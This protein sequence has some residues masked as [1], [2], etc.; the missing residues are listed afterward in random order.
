MSKGDVSFLLV[1]TCVI[2]VVTTASAFFT[3]G[4]YFA[5]LV[6]AAILACLLFLQHPRSALAAALIAV[7]V[8]PTLVVITGVSRVSLLDDGLTLACFIYLPLRRVLGG[9]QLRRLPG[10][11][12]FVLV[13]TAGLISGLA[14]DVP[15]SIS[16][17]GGYLL[18][19]GPMLGY[20]AAQLDWRQSDVV[21]LRKLVIRAT[22]LLLTC[23]TANLALP[24]QWAAVFASTGLAD[25]RYS[26]IASLLGPFTHPSFMG[27][28]LGLCVVA[29]LAFDGDGNRRTWPLTAL[30][31]VAAFL[32][33]RRKTLV[34]L[35]LAVLTVI[36]IRSRIA[37]MSFA[38]PLVAVAIAFGWV[39]I[40]G[41]A[42]T[43]YHAYFVDSTIVPRV[44]MYQGAFE[45]GAEHFPLGAGLGRWG[46]EIAVTHYS[47]EYVKR[48]FEDYYGLGRSSDENAFATDTFWPV[49]LGETGYLGL[50]GYVLAIV[51][52]IRIFRS[53]VRSNQPLSRAMGTTGVGWLMLL[54]WE[55]TAAPVFSGPPL[56]PWLFVAAGL[57]IASLESAEGDNEFLTQA[58][59]APERKSSRASTRPGRPSREAWSEGPVL[60]SATPR[61]A[62]RPL[63]L[64]R[65]S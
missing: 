2:G 47:P 54:L 52:M 6:A 48:G 40:T 42:T 63:R 15:L 32:T 4:L 58:N 23:A 35:P 49:V 38:V 50:L 10:Q 7:L 55:S 30:A 28:I 25:Y 46:S 5:V 62:G 53:G 19:K 17:S 61:F 29:L 18:M 26:S 33:F 12:C 9:Q 45:L 64:F 16:L 60:Q 59:S 20:A 27:Q 14:Q 39:P 41:I 44:L 3:D 31:S 34:S 21:M 37:L 56:Y 1:A 11:W 36:G 8:T 43:T 22:V 57:T 51:M 65:A 13:A 24:D